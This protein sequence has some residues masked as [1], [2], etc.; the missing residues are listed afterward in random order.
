M[1]MLFM[2][3]NPKDKNLDSKMLSVMLG[4]EDRMLSIP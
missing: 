1:Y 4:Y 3:L 2:I